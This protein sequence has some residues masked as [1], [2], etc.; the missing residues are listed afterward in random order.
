MKK[1][2]LLLCTACFMM[3]NWAA[4][5]TSMIGSVPTQRQ[6]EGAQMTVGN[7]S[8]TAP[9]AEAPKFIREHDLVTV[10]VK[11]Y[12]RSTTKGAMERKKK[13]KTDYSISKWP[14]IN[15]FGIGASKMADG[16]PAIGADINTKFKNEGSVERRE[17]VE[18]RITCRVISIEANG[19]LYLEGTDVTTLG[20]EGKILYFSGYADPRNIQPDNTVKGELINDPVI[21]EVTSG[22]VPD[23]YQRNWGQKLIDRYS[24]F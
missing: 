6:L 10:I 22:S 14:S 9:P 20:E 16:A 21:K 15:L 3:P 7:M 17:Q 11:N 2:I 1:T 5:Q 23:S 18:F 13:M 19:V 4:A 12:W 24:P 8:F